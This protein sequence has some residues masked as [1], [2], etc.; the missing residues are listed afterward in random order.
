[1]LHYTEFSSVT[2]S[3]TFYKKTWYADTI[4]TLDT[5]TTSFFELGGQW[6]QRGRFADGERPTNEIGIVYIWQVGINDTVYYGRSIWE[7]RGFLLTLS[8]YFAGTKIIIWVHNLGYDF[9]F[10]SPLFTREWKV[11]CRGYHQPIYAEL[12]EY[13]IEFRCSYIL[14]NLSLDNAGK[15]ANSKRQKLTGFF[16]YDVARLPNTPLSETELAYCENDCLVLYD[17]IKTYVD[18][19][20]TL[21][22]IPY[23]Q[24]GE[25]RREVKA[26]LTDFNYLSKIKLYYP[27]GDLWRKITRVF[28]GGYT[29]LNFLY[30]G[31]IIS[32]VK[33]FDRR[34][35]YP[36]VMLSERYPYGEFKRC[37]EMTNREFKCY[38]GC[39]RFTKIQCKNAWE[40]ISA[41]KCEIIQNGKCDNG[42]VFRADFIE[43]WCT[44]VDYDCICK[45]YEFETVETVE[46]YGSLSAYLPLP[47]INYMLQLYY[48]KTALKGDKEQEFLYKK[49]KEYINSIFGM[50]CTNNIKPEI[51]FDDYYIPCAEMTDE[52]IYNKLAELKPFLLYQWGVWI[53]AYARQAVLD[54][55]A[56]DS[57]GNDIVY[58]DTDS[59]KIVNAE[60]WE[61]VI[62]D[63]NTK[64]SAKMQHVCKIRQLDFAKVNPAAPDGTICSL[65]H[66][67]LDGVYKKFKSLGAKKYIVEYEDGHTEAT[68]AGCQKTYTT[69]ENGKQVKKQ[70]ITDFDQLS[71]GYA[72]KD[73]RTVFWYNPAQPLDVIL[74]DYLGNTYINDCP[75]GAAMVKAP[76]TF[77]ISAEYRQFLQIM[78]HTTYNQFTSPYRDKL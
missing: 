57:I 66:F 43:L 62:N 49:S 12:T 44:D 63:Y 8:K 38:F 33:S 75:H 24:T 69:I 36:A 58:I 42:R 39:F 19:Y 3:T 18:K 40:C 2:Y 26:L 28:A 37:T 54:F 41:H 70:R 47:L 76:Y 34:S 67:A 20:G 60:K 16:D 65:G 71:V 7:L 45:L 14:T 61:N 50:C 56:V 52:D 21:Q 31:E 72:V 77:G 55:C 25:V 59:L 73:G 5:E 6:V 4:I 9:E 23:T 1:M 32:N 78:P 48:N 35:S 29:H 30:H 17:V 27:K 13:N 53:T 15:R 68:V 11:F 22:N 10:I 64:L 74:T 51:L 46:L